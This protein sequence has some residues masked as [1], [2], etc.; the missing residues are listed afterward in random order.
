MEDERSVMEFERGNR[1][2][3]TFKTVLATVCRVN[4]KLKKKKRLQVRSM[5]HATTISL[6]KLSGRRSNQNTHMFA[7]H[8][9]LIRVFV[10]FTVYST[11]LALEFQQLALEKVSRS[12]IA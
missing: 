3:Q 12:N 7:M 1:Q 4:A 9:R 2:C 6:L 11:E 10:I 8:F 5:L